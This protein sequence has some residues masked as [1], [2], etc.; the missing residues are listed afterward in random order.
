MTDAPQ[1]LG[2]VKHDPLPLAALKAL[3]PRQWTKNA[4]VY[5]ALFFSFNFTV[6]EQVMRASLGFLAFCL[7]SST[8]Y[9]FNDLRDAEADRLHP[10]KRKR[11]IAS[12][13]VTPG[14]AWGIM[15]T[16][17]IGGFG[18]ALAVSPSFAAV[19]LL[20]FVTT[21]SYTLIF[22]NFVILDIMLLAAGFLWRAVAG[23]VAI[24]VFISPWLLLC[25][26]FLALFIG[27]NKRRGELMLLEGGAAKHR[28]NLSEYSPALLDEF[29]AIT[30]SGTVISYALYT[31][32]A[33]P[34]PYLLATLPYVLYVIFRY[35]YLVQ[36]GGDGGDPSGTL[37]RD[38]PILIT[39]LLYVLT[40]ILILVIAGPRAA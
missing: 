29:Q 34:T 6:P 13:A 19:A 23:A 14:L 21:F 17:F 32:L 33:S 40:T 9:V 5:A 16:C 39:G 18:L 26:G 28:K 36:S 22:K 38:K 11:P 8:G 30:T 12:G 35:I 37:T 27:F 31:V 24:D 2:P 25:T 20:Y 3:R 7:I 1:D 10:Q 15:V 4:F